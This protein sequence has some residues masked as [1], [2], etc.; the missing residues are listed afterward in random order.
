MARTPSKMRVE[1]LADARVHLAQQKERAGSSE[2]ARRMAR[3]RREAQEM[4]LCLKWLRRPPHQYERHDLVALHEECVIS[5]AIKPRNSQK[6]CI[7]GCATCTSPC[8]MGGGCIGAAPSGGDIAAVALV[9]GMSAAASGG[10]IGA[11][12]SLACVW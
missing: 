1:Q 3:Q 11:D 6:Y 12:T 2:L 7:P 4:L 5:R 10:C 8:C 9:G